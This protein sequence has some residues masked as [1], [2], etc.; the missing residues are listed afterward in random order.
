MTMGFP[1][2]LNYGLTNCALPISTKKE[3]FGA[4]LRAN[5]TLAD[6]GNV[7]IAGNYRSPNFGTLDQTLNT[8]DKAT[9]Y[10]YD[11]AT[12][13]ELSKFLPEKL[14]LRIPMHFDYSQI[15][16]NPEYDPNQTD[17]LFK[18]E[19]KNPDISTQMKI[20]II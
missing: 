14:G 4:N 8:T 11:I 12:N 15:F 6:L 5:I 9:T 3:G 10:Q 2:A 13:L 16:S 20:R 17:V 19:L 7:T 1:N 18:D